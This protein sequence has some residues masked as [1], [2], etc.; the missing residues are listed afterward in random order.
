MEKQSAFGE[1]LLVYRDKFIEYPRPDYP[2]M[3][4]NAIQLQ[5]HLLRVYDGLLLRMHKRWKL[6]VADLPMTFLRETCLNMLG[7]G[8]GVVQAVLDSTY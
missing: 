5:S 2:I 4:R 1:S 3:V 7:I 6:P 8:S